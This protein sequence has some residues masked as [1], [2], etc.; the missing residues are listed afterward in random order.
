M[1]SSNDRKSEEDEIE[2]ARRDSPAPM[3]PT[4]RFEANREHYEAKVKAYMEKQNRINGW[5]NQN[6]NTKYT[7]EETMEDEN[8]ENK[9]KVKSRTER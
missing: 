1:P 2:V 6:N 5:V 8:K 9:K 3:T 4:Q 7:N